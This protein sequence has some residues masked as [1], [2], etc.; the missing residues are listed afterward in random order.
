MIIDESEAIWR[1]AVVTS[2]HSSG[3]IEESHEKP[4]R[5]AGLRVEIVNRHLPTTNR[6]GFVFSELN[7]TTVRN[8]V[9]CV[10]SLLHQLTQH[11]SAPL[12]GHPQV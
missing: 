1:E 5:M 4:V 10:H 6:D 2:R 11:V 3:G 9:F 12:G 8:A 7:K